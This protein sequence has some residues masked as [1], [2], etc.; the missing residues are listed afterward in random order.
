MAHA[1][2]LG[3]RAR[4]WQPHLQRPDLFDRFFGD[5]Q[6]LDQDR[7]R[8]QRRGNEVHVAPFVDDVLGHEPVMI[9]DAALDKIAGIAEVGAIGN[10]GAAN[11]VRAGPTHGGDD[12]VARLQARDTAANLNHFAQRFV[13]YDQMLRTGGRRSV[14]K[15]ANLAVG[16]ADSDIKNSE[17]CLCRSDELGLLDIDKGNFPLR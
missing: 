6:R 15:G 3:V 13:S 9:L 16:A 7:D 14:L 8:T 17:L 11:L 10:A 4:P 2:F 5:C 1:L 12:Q